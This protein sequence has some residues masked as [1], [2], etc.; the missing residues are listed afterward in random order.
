MRMFALCVVSVVV[1]F[2]SV[3]VAS[4]TARADDAAVA[5]AKY[6]SGVRHY[7]LS[8]WEPALLDFKEAYRNKPDPVFLY[9]IA[10]C[11]RK[12]GHAEEAITF[13]QTYLRRAPDANN[14]EEVERRISE[15]S[16]E[17][18]G[19]SATPSAVPPAT[20]S[21]SA[22]TLSTESSS[23]SPRPP[24]AALVASSGGQP[25]R[26]TRRIVALGLG[27]LGVIGI[28]V[29]SA[30]ALAAR[31]SYQDAAGRCPNRVCTDIADKNQADDARTRG[32]IATAIWIGGIAA[33]AGGT[34]LWLVTP[35]DVP[36]ATAVSLSPN[37][38]RSYAGVTLAGGFQ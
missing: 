30:V 20:A 11:H 27:G 33:L 19:T 28:G 9:N 22:P 18:A 31:S 8:E 14:R 6:E 16:R 38:G 1:L 12:L 5:K 34:I 3:S 36:R 7:D 10:Q 15:L 29:G 17:T 37:L 26:S 25:A 21:S 2:L 13:Y 4:F 24:G 35:A 23:T 32:N